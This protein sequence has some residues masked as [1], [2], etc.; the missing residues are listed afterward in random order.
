VLKEGAQTFEITWENEDGSA[1]KH[2]ITLH[3]T[4]IDLTP[5]KI[6]SSSP[7]NGE[8]EVSPKDL[9]EKGITIAF[10]ENIDIKKTK[11]NILIGDEVIK[12]KPKWSDDTKSVTL[13]SVRGWD[14]SYESEVILIVNAEDLAGNKLA[15]AKII[16]TTLVTANPWRGES[17]DIRNVIGYW[18]FEFDEGDIARNMMEHDGADNGTIIGAKRVGGKPGCDDQDDDRPGKALEFDGVDD[19][20]EVP[21]SERLNITQNI[22]ITAWIKA[23]D[24]EGG[25]ILDKEGA[26]GLSLGEGLGIKWVIFGDEWETGVN[27]TPNVWHHIALVY[28]FDS[29]KRLVYL[30]GKLVA[31]K[32]TEIP[33]PISDK[34]LLIGKSFHGVIDEVSLWRSALNEH[35]LS[36]IVTV[37]IECLFL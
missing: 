26:Y 22:T 3:V 20:V 13:E 25:L 23:Y 2:T 34:P 15:D 9:N 16:F 30:N 6:I 29:Q 33:I 17:P 7:K 21:A 12:W 31:E 1:G 28:D 5:P 10:N 24:N 37:G 19:M 11:I 4:P 27:I 35:H 8:K 32:K 36:Q 14:I 18:S